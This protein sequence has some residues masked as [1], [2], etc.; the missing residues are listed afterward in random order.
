MNDQ[1]KSQSQLIDELCELRQQ[2]KGLKSAR[3]PFSPNSPDSLQERNELK[4]LIENASD[5]IIR[6]N[7]SMGFLFANSIAL[8]V[9][10]I[11]STTYFGKTP[12][13][14]CQA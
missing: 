3:I 10:G 12:R 7:Q 11:R 1:H 13:E 2:I 9:L 4:M 5:V 8:K 6:F 14:G